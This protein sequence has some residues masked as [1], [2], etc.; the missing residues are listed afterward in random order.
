MW[1]GVIFEAACFV[2]A[3]D[4]IKISRLSIIGTYMYKNVNFTHKRVMKI[5]R[6]S[7]INRH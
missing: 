4:Y 5:T 2:E 1:I 6:T 3:L 7:N